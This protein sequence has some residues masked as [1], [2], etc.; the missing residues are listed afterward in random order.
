VENLAEIVFKIL[1][2]GVLRNETC[3]VGGPK[4]YSMG[5]FVRKAL[6]LL[7]YRR[8]VL[9]PPWWFFVPLLPVLT[10]LK[11]TTWENLRMVRTEN[12]CPKNCTAKVLKRVKDPFGIN[13][14]ENLKG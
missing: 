11:I 8:V 7:G 10:P 6:N 13:V 4:V 1:T 3:E 9:E 12:V 5:E 14:G 2:E